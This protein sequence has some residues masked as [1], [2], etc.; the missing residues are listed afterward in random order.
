VTARVAE[1]V[2]VGVVRSMT[3]YGRAAME[4]KGRQVTAE[5]RSVN[6]RF[7]KLGIKVPGRFGV[8]EDKIKTLLNDEGIRRGSVDVSLFFDSGSGEENSYG[9]NESAVRQYLQQ[10]RAISKKNKLKGDLPLSAFLSLPDVVKRIQQDDDI[11]DVWG[12]SQKVLR[13]AIVL[14]GEMRAREGASMVADLRLQLKKLNEHWV[15]IERAAP[16][17]LKSGVARFKERI[18]RLL[19]EHDVQA[20][21]NPDVLEREVV[22]M[23]DRTDVSEEIARL[24]SHFDQMESTL[25]LGGEVGKKLDFLT[26]ELFRE[27]NTIGS[28]TNENGITHRVV[29]MKGLIEKIREQVQNLE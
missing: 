27:V 5:I 4:Y 29:D 24:K 12:V 26:Q 23:T 18:Q 11:D 8:F 14:F 25:L 21:L 19:K 3:G 15:E 22:L 1:R 9:I 7:L 16:E 28:K 20:P 13:K 10:A 6:G 2:S 17:A